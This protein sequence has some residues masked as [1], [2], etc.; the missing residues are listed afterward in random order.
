MSAAA[1]TAPSARYYEVGV[2]VILNIHATSENDAQSHAADLLCRPSTTGR[3]LG[4]PHLEFEW[5]EELSDDELEEAALA[6]HLVTEGA[7][8]LQEESAS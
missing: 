7:A 3:V 5:C 1:A 8:A 4:A 6:Q 2:T